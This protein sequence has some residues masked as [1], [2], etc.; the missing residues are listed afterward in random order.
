MR[1]TLYERQSTTRRV[2]A[3]HRVARALEEVGR[4]TPAEIAH[5]YFESRHLDREGKAVEFSVRA[6]DA[7]T[8]AF[9]WEDAAEHYRHAL[10]RL[11]EGDD[12]RRCALLLA[13][14]GA[15]SRGGE[16]EA[17]ATFGAAAA[18]AR[19]HGLASELAQAALGCTMGYA[20]AAAID[21]EG[22]ELL[23]AALE[24]VSDDALAAQLQARLANV[25]HFAGQG[26]LVETLSARALELARRSG[27]PIALVS[28]L[29]ARQTALVQSA[30]LEQRVALARELLDLAATLGDRELKAMALHWHIYHLLEAGSVDDARRESRVL[31]HL[32]EELRQPTYLH[33][34]V[35]WETM[36]ALLADR[37]EE[38]QALIMRTY[39]IGKR[40]QAPEIDIEAAGRQLAVAWRHD[41]LGQFAELLEAQERENPQLGTNLPVMALAF[42]QAGD[43]DAARGVLA[44]IDID[45][46]A[47]DML[48]MAGMCILSQVCV[49]VGDVDARPGPVRVA[50]AASQAQRDGRHGE[51]H[52]LGRALPRAA[53]HAARR[54][55]VGR[56]P[57]RH[58]DHAQRRGRARRLLHDGPRRL[59]GDARGP[60]R[61]GRRVAGGPAAR[62]DARE[63]G[64]G[65]PGRSPGSDPACIAVRVTRT[66]YPLDGPGSLRVIP[67]GAKAAEARS[68]IP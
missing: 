63:H 55:P 6:G 56:G 54:L 3:H 16:P 67:N 1:E 40:A 25:L 51:L 50:A 9:A 53:R 57:L 28:A 34:A 17:V 66:P 43:L 62:G 11:G 39:E 20:Q 59:R 27:D 29:E 68:S 8:A 15:E 18:L 47:R 60:L 7:A 41:G 42:A 10:E 5:Q 44:R 36:W 19:S 22:I 2:R 14:G 38:V 13:L 48:W 23:E 26:E 65:D 21:T 52:G 30:D 58:R 45:A 61:P 37:P 33:F 35:R 32:A 24:L 12:A 46:L 4:A 31:A 49:L 64:R